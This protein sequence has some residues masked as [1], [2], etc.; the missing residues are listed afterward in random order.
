MTEAEAINI[1][2]FHLNKRHHILAPK[3]EAYVRWRDFCPCRA[4]Q[5]I[6]TIYWP[7]TVNMK[8]VVLTHTIQDGD[9]VVPNIRYRVAHC[10]GKPKQQALMQNATGERRSIPRPG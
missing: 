4:V 3:S 10:I 7:A 1:A 8:E 5:P 9:A 6:A 2:Y